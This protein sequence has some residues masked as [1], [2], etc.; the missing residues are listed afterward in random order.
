MVVLPTLRQLEKNESFREQWFAQ[1]VLQPGAEA[2]LHA[3]CDRATLLMA[4][5]LAKK[6][7]LPGSRA[8]ARFVA[9]AEL[10]AGAAP[11][12]PRKVQARRGRG[13]KR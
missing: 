13:E 5:G 8:A 12:A 4:R 10:D 1:P 7:G 2:W 9:A 6:R 11:G 3:W